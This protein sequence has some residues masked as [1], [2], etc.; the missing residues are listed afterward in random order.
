MQLLLKLRFHYFSLIVVYLLLVL[1]QLFCRPVV[2]LP[3][4]AD[5]WLSVR[6]HIGVDKTSEET[7]AAAA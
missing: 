4:F 1:R 5:D 3:S 7:A 2:D 6:E